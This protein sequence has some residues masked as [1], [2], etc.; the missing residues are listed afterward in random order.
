M[1]FHFLV[2]FEPQAGKEDE[3]RKQLLRQVPQTQAE[4]DCLLIRAL[5]SLSGPPRFAIYSEWTDEA[6]FERHVELP[7]TVT[8]IAA[9]EKLLTHPV[10]GFR[11]RQIAGTPMPENAKP[12]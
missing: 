4:P 5:E 2:H 10:K 9:A 3:F 1:A 12:A 6:A 7:H 8:F 11:A